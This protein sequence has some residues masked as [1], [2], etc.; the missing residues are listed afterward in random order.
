MKKIVKIWEDFKAFLV[1]VKSELKKCSWPTRSELMDSTV[2]VIVSVAF[3][4]IFIGVSD[5]TI[6]KVLALIIK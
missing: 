1:G 3:F 6:M 5:W 2:V 4:G